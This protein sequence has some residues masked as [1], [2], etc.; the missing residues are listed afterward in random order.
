MELINLSLV[1]QNSSRTPSAS[2]HP[3]PSAHI[4]PFLCPFDHSSF[5]PPPPNHPSPFSYS[6][7][8]LSAPCSQ[9]PP[10]PT[11]NRCAS[12]KLPHKC[13]NRLKLGRAQE[14]SCAKDGHGRNWRKDSGDKES[15][16]KL[17]N[18]TKA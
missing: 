16:K 5:S 4:H 9:L 2:N 17:W 15:V 10:P 11:A 13:S 18:K 1:R 3:L 6:Q 12:S 8:F 7:L 14:T